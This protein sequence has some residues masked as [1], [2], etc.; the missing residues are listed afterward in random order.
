[1]RIGVNPT[2]ALQAY[3]ESGGRIRTQSWFQVAAEER[4]KLGRQPLVQNAPLRRR[5]T[6]EEISTVTSRRA[7]G[8]DYKFRIGGILGETGEPVVVFHSVRTSR[9]MRY[10]EVAAIAAGVVTMVQARYNRTFEPEDI[11][12]D[13]VVEYIPGEGE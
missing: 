6:F 9:L 7:R 5:P 13:A 1:M 3:R 4:A 10:S 8:Y 11:S 2:T 12:L